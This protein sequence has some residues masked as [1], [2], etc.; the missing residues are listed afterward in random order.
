MASFERSSDA[1]STRPSARARAEGLLANVSAVRIVSAD[2]G[3]SN[4]LL[5]SLQ[6]LFEDVVAVPGTAEGEQTG[7]GA[8][9]E[10]LRALAVAREDRVVVV[11]ADAPHPTPHL[12]LALTA[13]PE[14]DVVIPRSAPGTTPFCAIYRRDATL[15]AA[16]DCL[17]MADSGTPIGATRCDALRSVV[18]L[19]DVDVIEEVDLTALCGAREAGA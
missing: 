18:A 12:W 4:E 19:L 10:L 13:W 8:L 5:A 1:T 6:S 2:D 16:R 9:R 17:R 15:A 11:A 14:H 7:E 3:Q